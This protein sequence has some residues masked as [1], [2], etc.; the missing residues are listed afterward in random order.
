MG[1]SICDDR[2]N[3]TY[4]QN[5]LVSLFGAGV[6]AILNVRSAIIRAPH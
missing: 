6:A 4:A 5:N 2:R 3:A 1:R